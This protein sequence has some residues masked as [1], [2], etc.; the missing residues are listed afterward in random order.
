MNETARTIVE[1]SAPG[2]PPLVSIVVPCYC[3]EEMLPTSIPVL[4]GLVEKLIR[5]HVAAPGSELIFVDDGSTDR[6]WQI[7]RKAHAEAPLVV[8]GVRL[9]ANRGQQNA[10]FAGFEAAKGDFVIT[11]DSDLQDDVSVIEDMILEARR[12]VDIVYGVRKTRAKDTFFKRLTAES[13]YKLMR[14]LDVDLVYNHSEFRGMSRRALAALMQYREKGLFLRGLVRQM[15]FRTSNVYYARQERT[16]GATKYSFLKLLFTAMN[17]I[18]SFSFF[19]LRLV[20]LLGLGLFFLSFVL[21]V[22]VLWQKYVAH[23]TVAGWAS[24]VLALA[25]F[26]GIQLLCL[27]IIGEY[28]AVIFKEVKDRPRFHIQETTES[29]H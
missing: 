1:E 11:V 29:E 27:G 10:M 14:L 16:A 28:L 17:G 3:E 18:A 4:T 2:E 25:A 21:I 8:R 12:G 13:F 22:W 6:T 19:P 24:M 20:T 15:G 5:A 26:S 9:S 7:I 23:T